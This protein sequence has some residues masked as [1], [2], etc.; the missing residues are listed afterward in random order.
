VADSITGD[1]ELFVFRRGQAWPAEDWPGRRP[2]EILL[3]FD[4]EG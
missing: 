3:V 2:G 1:R 4:E